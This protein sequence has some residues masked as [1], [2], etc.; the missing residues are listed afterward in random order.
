MSPS[1]QITIG[2]LPARVPLAILDVR[3]EIDAQTGPQLEAA[4]AEAQRQ[5]ARHLVLDLSG[6]SFMGSAGMRA[7]I[8]IDEMLRA[9]TGQAGQGEGQ[10]TAT[11]SFKSPY[12]K[13]LS[14]PPAVAR[15]LR[16][17]GF[18]M[19]FNIFSDRQA[20]LDSFGEPDGGS[21]TAMDD[22]PATIFPFDPA[23]ADK[24]LAALQGKRFL[25][26]MGSYPGKRFMYE[27]ARQLGARL[28]VLDGPGHWT[29]AEV[30]GLFEQFI[31][32]DLQPEDSLADRALA[33]VRRSNLEFDGVA[34]FEEFAGPLTALLAQGL[35][36]AGHPFLSAAYCRDK[37]LTRE[38][39]IEAGIP[40]PCFYRIRAA[41]DLA[42]AAAHVGFPAVLKPVSGA[43]SVSTYRV[44]DEDQLARRYAQTMDAV[45]GHLKASGVHSNDEEELIWAKGFDMTLEKFLDGEEFDVDCLLSRGAVAYAAVGRDLPQPYLREIGS[46]M[47]PD[48]PEDKQAEMIAFTA[49]VLEAMGFSEGSFHVELKYTAEGPRLIEVNARIGGLSVAKLHRWVWGVDLVGHYLM[50]RLGLPTHPQ[51]AAQPLA[52]ILTSYLPCPTSGVITHTDFLAD[53]VEEHLIHKKVTVTAGQ[54]VIGPDR[55]VPDA[56]GEIVV[57]AGSICEASA[58]LDGLLAMIQFPIVPA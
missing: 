53:I 14:P 39:C 9:Q 21:A 2:M 12:L 10:T 48:F 16:I 24:A 13:L 25:I 36:R 7:L 56:L 55:G 32:V 42:A 22:Q 19:I 44:D 41:D 28:V 5:G 29:Q 3:G 45:R 17:S 20:A 49:C 11:A 57:A 37:T 50:T 26:V 46:Q 40:S 54:T 15:T 51:K 34:T 23:A 6:V 30:G 1:F 35:K 18:E 58:I 31:E 52:C 43:S 8:A 38:V 4:A 27:R 33:A 47:P